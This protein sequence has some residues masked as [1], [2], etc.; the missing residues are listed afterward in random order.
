MN[1]RYFIQSGYGV[2]IQKSVSLF[3]MRCSEARLIKERPVWL[4]VVR[5]G[6]WEDEEEEKDDFLISDISFNQATVSP[7]R[8]LCFDEVLCSS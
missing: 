3:L 1:L 6:M 8:S 7:Y 2:S 4:T 5:R